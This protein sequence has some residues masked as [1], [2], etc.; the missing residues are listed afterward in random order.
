MRAASVAV[1]AVTA[2][3]FALNGFF[4]YASPL[5][6]ILTIGMVSSYAIAGATAIAGARRVGIGSYLGGAFLTIGV[7]M[8][9]MASGFLVE[10]YYKFIAGVEVPYPSVADAFFFLYTPLVVIGLWMFLKIHS[11]RVTRRLIIEAAVLTTLSIGVSFLFLGT[12][13]L[14]RNMAIFQA[15]SGRPANVAEI[16][17]EAT[18][19]LYLVTDAIYVALAV[20]IARVSGGK[21]SFGLFVFAV[22]IALM[23]AG[24]VAYSILVENGTYTEGD[25]SDQL[26]LA[27]G[28][29]QAL[30]LTYIIRPFVARFADQKPAPA[31][32]PAASPNANG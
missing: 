8:L 13:T 21:M 27:A 15:L 24:D 32:F 29:A 5:A 2:I 16:L 23:T 30:A 17:A 20:L 28:F 25:V 19:A 10:D 12:L 7:G 14:G 31:G 1:L 4:Y 22:G 9:S 3:A 18:S 6:L 26:F 11:M